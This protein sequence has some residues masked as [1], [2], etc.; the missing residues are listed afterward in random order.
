MRDQPCVGFLFR[1]YSEPIADMI[2]KHHAEVTQRREYLA[3]REI[4]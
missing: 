2:I 1:C 4:A 3:L